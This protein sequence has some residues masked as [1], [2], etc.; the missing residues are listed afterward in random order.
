MEIMTVVHE[1]N[2]WYL[3]FLKSRFPNKWTCKSLLS[4]NQ[5]CFVL[6]ELTY[7]TYDFA[8]IKFY[9]KISARNWSIRKVDKNP[10][11]YMYY[12]YD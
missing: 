4:I 1:I 6:C 5:K 10:H 12:V 11:S 9:G 2:R 7:I 3:E 8:F